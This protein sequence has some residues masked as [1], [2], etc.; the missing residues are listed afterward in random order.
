MPE[1]RA[2]ERFNDAHVGAASQSLDYLVDIVG[3]YDY[4]V[5]VA[6]AVIRYGLFYQVTHE[7]N[8]VRRN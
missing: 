2:F 7:K 8:A 3:H 1:L 5:V 6:V 4:L